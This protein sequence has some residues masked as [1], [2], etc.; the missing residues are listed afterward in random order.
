MSKVMEYISICRWY[1][2]NDDCLV[3]DTLNVEPGDESKM[4]ETM[5][6]CAMQCTRK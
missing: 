1:I 4:L 2:E 5:L 6:D 3:A